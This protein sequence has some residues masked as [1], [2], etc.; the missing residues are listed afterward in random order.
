M[1]D[2]VIAVCK[3]AAEIL[4]G[5]VHPIVGCKRIAK[6]LQGA[7]RV[8]FTNEA[9]LTIAAIETK[10]DEIPV[11]DERRQDDWHSRCRFERIAHVNRIRRRSSGRIRRNSLNRLTEI[12]H[13]LEVP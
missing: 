10:I 12:L 6:S 13:G 7:G 4:S 5:G 11:R 2:D 1:N 8:A 9:A 3:A